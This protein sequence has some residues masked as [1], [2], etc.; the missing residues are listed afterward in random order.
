ML[1]TDKIRFT[2]G[3]MILQKKIM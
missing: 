2:T 3:N 1:L